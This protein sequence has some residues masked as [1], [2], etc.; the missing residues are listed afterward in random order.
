MQQITS[1]ERNSFA[2]IWAGQVDQGQRGLLPRR[3]SD[4]LGFAFDRAT[5]R[6]HDGGSGDSRKEP[7]SRL[8]AM[9]TRHNPYLLLASSHYLFLDDFAGL[10]LPLASLCSNRV[11]LH[12]GSVDSIAEP[13][14]SPPM[15]RLRRRS[16]ILHRR[17]QTCRLQSSRTR[18]SRRGPRYQTLRVRKPT[19][20][21]P[22]C[23]CRR[24]R[25]RRPEG[26]LRVPWIS[27]IDGSSD[28]ATY[29]SRLR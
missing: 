28:A 23:R 3:Y 17:L 2:R 18:P 8:Q 1:H 22:G 9:H 29:S 16:R 7:K 24:P 14:R 25:P 11:S 21:S 20:P 19:R 12:Q 15:R 4:G 26:S 10:E 5:L 13:R 27:L 6:R